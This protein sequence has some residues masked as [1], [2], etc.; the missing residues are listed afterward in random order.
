MATAEVGADCFS[1]VL[2]CLSYP[3]ECHQSPSVSGRSDCDADGPSKSEDEGQDGYRR[4]AHASSHASLGHSVTFLSDPVVPRAPRPES[5]AW[6]DPWVLACCILHAAHRAT[7]RHCCSPHT[8][9]SALATSAGV[10]HAVTCWPLL[11]VPVEKC[12][13]RVLTSALFLARRPPDRM[14]VLRSASTKNAYDITKTE[15]VVY[16]LAGR[17]VPPGKGGREVR[18]RPLH[19]AAE[20]GVG[21]LQ[22]CVASARCANGA[23]CGAEGTH[24]FS[25]P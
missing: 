17:R 13:S 9:L 16:N 15:G 19:G 18:S 22:H 11:Q 7:R 6:H 21:P 20:A 10:L 4:C 1:N 23:A 12:N 8:W 25:A 3:A 2:E 5:L 14:L 24:L